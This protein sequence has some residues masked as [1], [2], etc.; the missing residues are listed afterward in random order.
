MRVLLN[1]SLIVR[2]EDLPH[3]KILKLFVMI[4]HIADDAVKPSDGRFM[5][6]RDP[7]YNF[8]SG[9]WIVSFKDDFFFLADF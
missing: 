9:G 2:F 3:N 1:Q 6:P 4:F 7:I 8:R 5:V